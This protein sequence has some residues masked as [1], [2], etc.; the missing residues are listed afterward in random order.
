M[1]SVTEAPSGETQAG[2]HS[3]HTVLQLGLDGLRCAPLC[4]QALAL[5]TR[6]EQVSEELPMFE[7]KYHWD[8]SSCLLF[9][10]ET[11][12]LH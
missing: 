6:A 12:R 3:F 1:T 11:V 9:N 4:D 8:E 2:C 7:E 10:L 5:H